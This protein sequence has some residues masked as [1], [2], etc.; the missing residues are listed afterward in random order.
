[1]QKVTKRATAWLASIGAVE[2]ASGLNAH[3]RA[4][5]WRAPSGTVWLWRP[6]AGDTWVVRVGAYAHEKIGHEQ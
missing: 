1:M 5:S 3:P 4:R 6:V 2:V